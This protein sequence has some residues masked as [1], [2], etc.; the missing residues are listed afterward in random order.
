M[1]LKRCEDKRCYSKAAEPTEGRP[2][3]SVSFKNLGELVVELRANPQRRWYPKETP[4]AGG[5]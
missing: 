3:Q 4:G 2:Y 5:G 1:W